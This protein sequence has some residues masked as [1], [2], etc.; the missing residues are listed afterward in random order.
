MIRVAPSWGVGLERSTPL[1][2]PPAPLST[3]T[4]GATLPSNEQWAPVQGTQARLQPAALGYNGILRP[5]RIL[6]LVVVRFTVVASRYSSPL[7][8]PLLLR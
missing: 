5:R 8:S 3:A 2:K 4:S 1:Q 6:F 7:G